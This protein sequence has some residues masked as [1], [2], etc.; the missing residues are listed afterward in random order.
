[1]IATLRRHRGPVT[2]VVLLVAATA[3][4][5][6]S[7]HKFDAGRPD[8][9]YLARAFLDGRLWL[10]R[11][12]GPYDVVVV[13]D[14]AYVPFPPFPAIAAAPLVAILGPATV[15]A[16]EPLV[17]ATLATGGLALCWWMLARIGVASIGDRLWLTVL[18][19][20]STPIWFS[21]TR[22]GVWHTGHLVAAIL[23][24]AGL[25][26]LFGRRRPLLM[27]LLAG[28]AFLTRPPVLLAL[29]LW[30]WS[31]FPPAWRTRATSVVRPVAAVALGVAP[32]ALFGLWYNWARFGSPLE[33][34]YYLAALPAFLEARRAQGLFSLAHLPMN[35]ELFL[36]RL[37]SIRAEFP[38]FVPD[39][40]GMSVLLTS[41]GLL[42]ALRAPF[43]DPR[44]VALGIT[45]LAVLLPNLLYYGGGWLQMG[46]RYALDAIPFA[47]ALAGLGAARTGL[48]RWAK[49]LIAAGLAVGVGSVYWAYNLT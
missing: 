10:D 14:R 49:A 43:R 47:I 12:F 6:V 31:A 24:F 25:V 28:A 5:W 17:N 34:G 13:G 46:Y 32:A 8:L 1:V 37:P 48:P 9:F 40:L 20:F 36:V 27:G 29:P 7:A 11:P 19:G 4:Y 39:G 26:E 21:T 2:L 15:T 30:A 35:L 44:A 18:W 38:F 33:S 45:F 23:T 41:P 42:A 22:G 3:V 16:W